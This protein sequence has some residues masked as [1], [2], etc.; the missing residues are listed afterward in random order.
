MP[1]SSTSINVCTTVLNSIMAEALANIANQ[2][3]NSNDF[4]ADLKRVIVNLYKKHSRIV[5]N[6]NSYTEEWEKEAKKRGLK[7]IKKAPEAFK[8]FITKESIEMFEEFNV[9]REQELISRYNIKMEKYIKAVTTESKVMLEIAKQDIMPQAIKYA[10][11][12]QESSS[13]LKE[14]AINQKVD[15]IVNLINELNKKIDELKETLDNTSTI[16]NIEEKAKMCSY[17]LKEKMGDLRV[18][19]DTLEENLPKEYWPMPTYSDLLD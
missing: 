7:N 2:L 9:Y 1:G 13:V 5:Y 14:L 17:D 8:A 3:E 16:K 18:I 19:V 15:L 12:M 4:Y 11:F 6:G 10:V